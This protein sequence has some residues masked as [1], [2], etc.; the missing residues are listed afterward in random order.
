[1]EATAA[2]FGGPFP[3]MPRTTPGYEGEAGFRQWHQNGYEGRVSHVRKR[4][5]GWKQCSMKEFRIL[6][7]ANCPAQSVKARI[8]MVGSSVVVEGGNNM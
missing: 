2:A 3:S 1:M 6:N 7:V 4:I 5:Q 8:S